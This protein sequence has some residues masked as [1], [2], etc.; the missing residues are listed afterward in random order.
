MLERYLDSAAATE[1]LGA[2]LAEALTPGCV[3]YLRGDLGAGKTTL[4]RGLLRGLGHRGTVK[5]P[6]F[7]LV[8][9][10]QLEEWRL[11]HW[12]LYRLTDPEE[13]EYL[14]L[15]DQLDGEAVLLIEWPERGRGELPAADLDVALSYSGEARNCRVE[16]RSPTG[17][18]M[19]ARLAS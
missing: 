15:R 1:A 8:E 11:F 16:A 12:D 7:T 3:L 18:A 2:R 17:Q 9:P 6:T 4:A 14:G 5:S 10:Y 19:L 13:L